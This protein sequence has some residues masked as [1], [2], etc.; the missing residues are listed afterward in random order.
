MNRVHADAVLTLHFMTFGRMFGVDEWFA[1]RI[2]PLH[3]ASMTKSAFR[4]RV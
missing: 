1:K 3:V 2:V 4:L